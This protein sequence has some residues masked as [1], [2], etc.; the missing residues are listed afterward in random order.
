MMDSSFSGLGAVWPASRRRLASSQWRI[1][2]R[3]PSGTPSM[4]EITSTGNSAEKSATA[5]KSAGSSRSSRNP[6][7]TSRIM[8]SSATM[9]R[10]VNTRLTRARMTSCSGGSI[11]MIWR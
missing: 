11:M 10:G 4:R 5:S 8:G 2:W 6:V 9:A 3:S 7:I 1:C